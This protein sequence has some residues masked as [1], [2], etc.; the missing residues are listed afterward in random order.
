MGLAAYTIYIYLPKE[1]GG[2]FF[3]VFHVGMLA[4]LEKKPHLEDHPTKSK[5]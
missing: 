1:L 4:R 2:F 5:W 3:G